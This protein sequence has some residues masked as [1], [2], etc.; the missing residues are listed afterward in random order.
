MAIENSVSNVFLFTFVDSINVF[1][2][3]LSGVYTQRSKLP[4]PAGQ[5]SQFLSE[6]INM[7]TLYA[8]ICIWADL[9]FQQNIT[10]IHRWLFYLH[11]VSTD[12]CN[13][14]LDT[15]VSA[16]VRSK[17]VLGICARYHSISF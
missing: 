4:F 7:H 14:Q 16:C 13:V 1:G 10:L 12:T 3:H 5:R 2:C 11:V 6:F 17:N 8:R 15:F 9:R